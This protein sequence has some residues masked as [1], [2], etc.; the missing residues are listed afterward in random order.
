MPPPVLILPD[1]Q[2]Q[3]T[4]APTSNYEQPQ[5]IGSCSYVDANP[6]ESYE[7][8]TDYTMAWMQSP[9]D[10]R[11]EWLQPAQDTGKQDSVATTNSIE[12]GA[13]STRP[14]SYIIPHPCLR[15]Y[16]SSSVTAV[17][18]SDADQREFTSSYVP[19]AGSG[20]DSDMYYNVC[21]T[22]E[23]VTEG[24]DIQYTTT[25]KKHVITGGASARPADKSSYSCKMQV[26]CSLPNIIS[27][28]PKTTP[29]KCTTKIK[30]TSTQEH[31]AK[32]SSIQDSSSSNGHVYQGLKH[33]TMNYLSLYHTI[34]KTAA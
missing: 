26:Q 3:V 25:A 30:P 34:N 2:D 29:R 28:K 31:S 20:C 11:S 12:D 22:L 1:S 17:S 7:E 18:H 4:T 33:E 5:V 32:Q 15:R 6:R 8:I 16:S 19:Y 13:C 9:G 24:D 23:A 27:K 21:P 14:E 10:Y